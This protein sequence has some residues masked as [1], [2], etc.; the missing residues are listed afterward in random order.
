M[1]AHVSHVRLLRC[2]E[3]LAGESLTTLVSHDNTL[4]R[5]LVHENVSQQLP[6]T[7]EF[8]VGLLFLRLLRKPLLEV[9]HKFFIDMGWR[10]CVSRVLQKKLDVPALTLVG[11]LD[12]LGSAQ[13]AVS[14]VLVL[15]L[16]HAPDAEEVTTVQPDW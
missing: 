14:L 13:R 6:A 16:D 2:H 11:I 12:H 4:G 3:T 5:L 10:M 15:H 7:F 8:V 1:I 9:P